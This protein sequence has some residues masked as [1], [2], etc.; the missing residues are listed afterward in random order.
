MNVALR[1]GSLLISLIAGGVISAA[2]AFYSTLFVG[3]VLPFRWYWLAV[4]AGLLIL[5]G[6]L[7]AYVAGLVADLEVSLRVLPRGVSTY[8]RIELRENILGPVGKKVSTFFWVAL[9]TSVLGFGAVS[10]RFVPLSW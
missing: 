10:L 6:C 2:A 9:L 4:S 8:V 7:W 5:S 3:E 1:L